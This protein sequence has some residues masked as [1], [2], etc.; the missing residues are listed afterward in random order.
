[1]ALQGADGATAN[2]SVDIVKCAIAASAA[3]S[4]ALGVCGLVVEQS[5]LIR[6]FLLK[7]E[8]LRAIQ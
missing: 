1:M 2:A 5:D 6:T 4:L 3:T 8:V 7:P